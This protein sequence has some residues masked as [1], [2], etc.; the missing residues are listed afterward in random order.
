MKG[1]KFTITIGI[2]AYNE[3]ANIYI[4]LRSII[5]QKISEGILEKII[6]IS[7]GSQDQTVDQ[8]KRINDKRLL[9]INNNKRQGAMVV[10]NEIL[11]ITNSDI[12]IMLDADVILDGNN[13]VNEI[14]KPI[15]KDEKV[16]L[17]G[18]DTV[19]L[20]GRTFIE[21][22]VARSHEF[23]RNIYKKIDNGNNIYLCH[24][25]AR[26]FSKKLYKDFE[27]PSESPEDAFSYLVC[28]KNNLKFKY[29]PNAVI[30][31]SSPSSLT[32]HKK[33]SDRFRKGKK[34]LLKFFD[35]DLVNAEYNIP[36]TIIM[37]EMFLSMVKSPLLMFLY[38]FIYSY[39]MLFSK[40]RDI[41]HSKIEPSKSSKTLPL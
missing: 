37:R 41:D 7:D 5:S 13:F 28:I 39:L 2:P 24:G 14:I 36:A 31:F 12:L 11:K 20:A 30:K 22:V 34:D 23:K 17:V 16:G 8:A 21:M 19:S 32:D 27:W 4:L 1:K 40:D 3:E 6:V 18:A 26:A 9:V 35:K 10:Q 38:L 15:I 25:R 29:S 33:Q